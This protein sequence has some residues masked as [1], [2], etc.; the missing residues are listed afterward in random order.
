MTTRARDFDR[1]GFRSRGPRHPTVGLVW[2][3]QAD[4]IIRVGDS[5]TERRSG[6]G[7]KHDGLDMFCDAGTP[8]VAALSG[9]VVQVVDGRFASRSH[10]RR[11]GLFADVQGEDG[12][13]YRYLHLGMCSL[14]ERQ[15]VSRG[16]LV[17]E[18]AP[19]HTSGAGDASHLHFEIRDGGIV[20]HTYA[21]PLDPLM[22]LPARRT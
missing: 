12:R 22:L 20:N 9:R 21:R 19:A 8:V 15:H 7:E 4:L 5:V 2:P 14:A 10:L 1:F 6:S 16:E 18:V 11:A 3:I 13:L 17:G